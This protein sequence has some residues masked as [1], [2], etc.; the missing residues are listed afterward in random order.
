MWGDSF[1]KDNFKDCVL[2]L[3]AQVTARGLKRGDSEFRVYLDVRNSRNR[4]PE[5][6]NTRATIAALKSR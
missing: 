6:S 1:K 2:R 4:E 3:I 5:G